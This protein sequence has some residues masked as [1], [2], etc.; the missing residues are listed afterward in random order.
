MNKKG[1]A[2]LMVLVTLLVVVAL[3]NVI[4]NIALSQTRLT[5][6]KISRIRAYYAAMAGVK[7]AYENL[8]TLSWV[9]NTTYCI[10]CPLGTLRNTIDPALDPFVVRIIIGAQFPGGAGPSNTTPIS[11]TATYTYQPI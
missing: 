2:L 4:M 9:Y 1:I 5:H 11:A 8:R 3:A 10:N 7:L 6:H